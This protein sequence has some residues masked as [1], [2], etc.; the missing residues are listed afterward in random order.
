MQTIAAVYFSP[1]GNTRKIVH[2]MLPSKKNLNVVCFDITEEASRGNLKSNLQQLEV[3]PDF[4]IFGSPVYSG[5]VPQLFKRAILAIAGAGQ[6]AAGVVTYGN[7]SYGAA[8]SQLQEILLNN[9]F[10]VVALGA[11]VGEHSYS[12][13][14]HVGENRPDVADLKQAECFGQRILETRHYDTEGIAFGGK[15]DMVARMMPEGGPKPFVDPSLCVDCSV[16]IKYCPINA[17]DSETK[18]Y[19]DAKTKKECISCMSCVKRCPAKARSYH[20]PLP[21]HLLLDRFY[22]K[23]AKIRYQ[24]PVVVFK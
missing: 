19:K 3:V 18:H 21:M 2:A 9:N 8:P 15:I 13:K 7:K 17:I 12:E 5:Q 20:I 4:W 1:T 22:F 16:C 11:F 14:F 23:E 10:N 6:P 24:K